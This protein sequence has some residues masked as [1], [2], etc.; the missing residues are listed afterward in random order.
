LRNEILEHAKS[1]AMLPVQTSGPVVSSAG[2][3]EGGGGDAELPLLPL[4]HAPLESAINTNAHRLICEIIIL[5]FIFV[6]SA[7]GAL[8]SYPRS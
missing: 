6:F 5:A 1:P 2:G 4:L 3:G 8:Y 7:D